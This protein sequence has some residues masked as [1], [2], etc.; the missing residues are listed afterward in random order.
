M[1]PFEVPVLW[2]KW[3]GTANV[4][5]DNDPK[6]VAEVIGCKSSTTVGAMIDARPTHFVTNVA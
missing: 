5:V 6:V 1:S 3:V 2:T 4:R